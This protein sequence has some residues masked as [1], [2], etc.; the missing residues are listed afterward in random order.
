M[1]QYEGARMFGVSKKQ[2]VAWEEGTDPSAPYIDLIEPLIPREC[3][4]ILRF[5]SGYSLKEIGRRMGVASRT[6]AKAERGTIG[7][8]ILIDFW[9]M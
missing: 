4:V 8:G 5:R 3:Y 1:S 7:P 9:G 2:Y 6:I